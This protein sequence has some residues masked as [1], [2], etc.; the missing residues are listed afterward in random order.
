MA[1]GWNAEV[2]GVYADF[3]EEGFPLIIRKRGE[4]GTWDPDQ[5]DWVGG[6]PNTDYPTFGLKKYKS[7]M[8]LGQRHKNL[9][10]PPDTI[11]EKIQLDTLFFPAKGLPTVDIGWT[12]VISNIEYRI[13]HVFPIDPGNVVLMYEVWISAG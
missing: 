4:K 13:A 6:T 7:N 1:T 11:S 12:V 5:G 9:G 8:F 3:K 10:S 2:D